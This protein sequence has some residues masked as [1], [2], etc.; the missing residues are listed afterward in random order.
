M[1]TAPISWELAP[2]LLTVS[3]VCATTETAS[4]VTPALAVAL[5]EISWMAIAIS[6]A[7]V[8]TV[9]RLNDT[10]AA[11]PFAASA[12]SVT[13]REP[14][15]VWSLMRVSSRELWASSCAP[16]ASAVTVSRTEAVALLTDR[17]IA[18]ISSRP[19]AGTVRLRLPVAMASIASAT[20]CRRRV[21]E[22]AMSSA[23]PMPASSATLSVT[24]TSRR[25]DT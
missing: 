1:T 16:S 14:E 17:A 7:P 6:S 2:S 13:A 18:P 23:N 4:M 5:C 3:V 9:C 10:S 11:E 12:W 24:I 19:D 20:G 22:P 8:A 15:T 21:M 25:A